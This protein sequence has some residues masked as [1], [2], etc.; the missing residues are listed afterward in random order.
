MTNVKFFKITAHIKNDYE[1][2]MLNTS[3]KKIAKYK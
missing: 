1:M 2:N 3:E